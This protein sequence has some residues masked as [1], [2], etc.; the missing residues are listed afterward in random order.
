MSR[1][2]QF[3]PKQLIERIESLEASIREIQA[4]PTE[5]ERN[6]RLEMIIAEIDNRPAAHWAKEYVEY[7]TSKSEN[8]F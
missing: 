3:A 1:Y 7:A 4:T 5:I 6:A 2:A 8:Y